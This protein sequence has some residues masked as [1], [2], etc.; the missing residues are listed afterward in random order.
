MKTIALLEFTNIVCEEK[1]RKFATFDYCLLK[2]VNRSYK[3]LS[4]KVLLH[5]SPITN[6]TLGL[7]F[8]KRANGYKPFLYNISLEACKFLRNPRS[9]PVAKY[10]I[11][12]FR[13]HSNM[14]HT[15]P[16]SVGEN[17]IYFW[18]KFYI[19]NIFRILS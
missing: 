15:C 6:I 9:N 10:M 19:L 18:L 16:Y 2:S 4:V 5:Q 11:D 3:Y 12:M 1:D 17:F 13:T 7:Q 14:N 8:L